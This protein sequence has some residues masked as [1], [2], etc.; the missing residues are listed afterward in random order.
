MRNGLYSFLDS[1]YLALIGL[2]V[3]EFEAFLLVYQAE[4][5]VTGFQSDPFAELV[6]KWLLKDAISISKTGK[7][8]AFSDLISMESFFASVMANQG[9]TIHAPDLEV[10]AEIDHVAQY[11]KLIR[12]NETYARLGRPRELPE[13]PILNSMF[14]PEFELGHSLHWLLARSER[15]CVWNRYTDFGI[16][17]TVINAKDKMFATE[18]E[19]QCAELQIPYKLV[20]AESGLPHW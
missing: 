12:I 3:A 18:L 14:T 15:V 19:N 2:P 7:I 9:I 6:A 17:P 4:S 16:Q 1:S 11:H 8:T 20:A 13:P 5:G 10:L